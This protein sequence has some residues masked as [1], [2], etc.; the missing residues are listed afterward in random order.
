MTVLDDAD[1][2]TVLPMTAPILLALDGT[3]LIHRSYHAMSSSALRRADGTPVWA[4]HGLLTTT[5][6]LLHELRPSA[7][8]I[9]LDP[10]G[11]CGWR[12]DLA[13]TYKAGRVG[14]PDDL[15]TQLAMAAELLAACGLPAVTVD[16]WEADDVLASATQR[17]GDRGWHSVVVSSDKDLHQLVSA[18]V[19]LHKPEGV[20]FDADAVT[21]RYGVHPSRWVE[22]AALVGEG[23]DNLGGVR[24]IGPAGALKLLAAYDDIDDAFDDI[25]LNAHVG[26]VTARKLVS[27]AADFARC[28][29]LGTLERTLDVDGVDVTELSPRAVYAAAAA[30]GLEAAGSKLAA[31]ASALGNIRTRR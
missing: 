5:A 20:I 28:R 11:G 24:G 25:N 10:P 31:A 27:G 13:P 14:T 21:A 26:A 19:T 29:R 15:R 18:T 17:A 1:A 6:K 22:Y 8:V 12:R 30:A 16:G 23:A 7:L 9:A 2:P 4:L 3:N